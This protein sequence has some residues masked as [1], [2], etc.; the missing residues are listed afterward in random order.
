[1]T[2][3][4]DDTAPARSI[5]LIGLMGAGKTSVGRRLAARLGLPFVD[6]DAEIEEAAGQSIPQIFETLGEPAFRDGERRVIARLLAG[7]PSV[8]ATG[9]GAWMDA[10]T[11]ALV[12]EGATSVWLKATV[13]T[14]AGRVK[15]K[16]GRPLLHGKDVHA[17]LTQLAEQ[18]YPVYAEADLTVQSRSGMAHDEMVR[19]ILEGLEQLEEGQ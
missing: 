11:R 1:M 10:E 7:P 9:G 16:P 12:R 18:R 14:L 13:A 19:R 3:D 5:V 8:I 17:V 15:D 2:G 6:S 4:Q